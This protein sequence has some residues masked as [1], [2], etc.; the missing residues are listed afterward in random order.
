MK[1]TEAIYYWFNTIGYWVKSPDR[2][3]RLKTW[4]KHG[5][6]EIF[7]RDIYRSLHK[8]DLAI[9][10]GAYNGD[11]AAYLSEYVLNDSSDALVKAFEPCFAINPCFLSE[12]IKYL[13]LP[14]Y[15]GS[16]VNIS[17]GDLTASVSES[18]V[19]MDSV[20]LSDYIDKEC[21]LKMDCEGAEYVIFEEL[22][23]SGKIDLVKEFVIEFHVE[24]EEALF[25]DMISKLEKLYKLHYRSDA[26]PLARDGLRQDIMVHGIRRK[27][28]R[29]ENEK[30]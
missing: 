12:R 7:L 28:R 20:K 19:E 18:G 9:D 22:I 3:P 5:S 11:S 16:K 17:G 6:S 1:I 4:L 25:G 13:F 27:Y 29:L 30:D 23:K 8:Y 14:V 21:F 15:D 24:D 10:V 26:C 2:M